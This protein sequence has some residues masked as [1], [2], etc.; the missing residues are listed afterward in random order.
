MA[1]TWATGVVVSFDEQ[2]GFGFIRS[3]AHREDVFVH[4]RVVSEGQ[5]LKPGQRVRFEAEPSENGPRAVWVRPGRVGLTPDWTW[6]IAVG[7]VV[8]ALAAA[9]HFVARW[10]WPVAWL[11]AINLV[12][13]AMFA[14]DK[15]QAIL[16]ERRVSELS[17]LALSLLGGTPSALLAMAVLRHKTHKGSFQMAFYGVMALQVAALAGMWWMS[18]QQG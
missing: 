10:S 11:G 2:H 16:G 7:I 14:W 18:R 13:F 15:R 1:A 4:A 17:L 8:A 12:T 6:A 5:T 9:G 3:H